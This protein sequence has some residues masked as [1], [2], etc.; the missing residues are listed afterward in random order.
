MEPFEL[1]TVFDFFV[2][3]LPNTELV[4]LENYKIIV[5]FV[6]KIT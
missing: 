4:Y 3:K 5:I 2:M 6:R 1:N